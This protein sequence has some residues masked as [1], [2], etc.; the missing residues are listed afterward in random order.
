[1]ICVK[2]DKISWGMWWDSLHLML[3]FMSICLPSSFIFCE[4][5]FFITTQRNFF[6]GKSKKAREHLNTSLNLFFNF[7]QNYIIFLT[8]FHLVIKQSLKEFRIAPL[9]TF[10]LVQAIRIYLVFDLQREVIRGSQS[11]GL[12]VFNQDSLI[13]PTRC[14]PLSN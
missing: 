3:I 14:A 10:L 8:I 9:N 11:R 4:I 1:M 6:H 7:L 12:L 5:I 13:C 2:R